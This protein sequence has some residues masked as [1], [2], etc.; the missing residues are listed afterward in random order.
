MYKNFRVQNFRGFKDLQLNDLARVNLIAGRNNVGKTALL[1]ALFI[2]IN[3]HSP[4]LMLRVNAIRGFRQ[5][6][7]RQTVDAA[8]V[9]NSVFREFDAL[10]GFIVEGNNGEDYRFTVK[11]VSPETANGITTLFD[12]EDI[13]RAA[14]SDELAKSIPLE[15]TDIDGEITTGWIIFQP[16]GLRYTPSSEARHPLFFFSSIVRETFDVL[17]ERHTRLIN[18]SKENL[19]LNALQIIDNRIISIRQTFQGGEPVI[20]ADMEGLNRPIPVHLMGDGM[21]RLLQFVLAIISAQDGVVLIDEIENGFHYSVLSDIWRYLGK[22]AEQYNVQIFATTHSREMIEAAHG[23][24]KDEK[25]FFRFHRL[26]RDKKT[27]EIYST[28]YDE[29]SIV[30]AMNVN[31]E[32]R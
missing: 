20:S 21:V 22:I 29:Y 27:S 10:R 32:V 24:F 25:D 31:A 19:L 4:E 1:E 15:I 2:F 14:S 6:Q 17:A 5:V 12:A 16:N 8:I 23:A 3:P 11:R 30:A 7:I 9:V 28:T 18:E 13:D 26:D